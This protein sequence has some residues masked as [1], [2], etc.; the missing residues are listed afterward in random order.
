MVVGVLAAV[1]FTGVMATTIVR[2]TLPPSPQFSYRPHERPRVF[3]SHH[4][5]RAMPGRPLSIRVTPD[6]AAGYGEVTKAVAWLAGP[7]GQRDSRDCSEN[8]AVA[9]YVCQ[10]ELPQG[11]EIY[12][13]GGWIELN[14]SQRVTAQTSYRFQANLGLTQR[15]VLREP[16]APVAA[17]ADTYRLEVAWVRDPQNHS[18]ADF[19]DDLERI[20]YEG[21]LKDPVYR[22]RD[23]Q[24]TFSVTLNSGVT[25]SYYS[26]IDTR[27]G[28]N[29]WPREDQPF[30]TELNH[31]AVLAVVHRRTSTPDV[32]GGALARNFRDCA[33]TLVDNAAIRTFSVTGGITGTPIIAKHEFGHAAFGLGDEYTESDD[34]RRVPVPPTEVP[35]CCCAYDGDPPGFGTGPAMA[36]RR[37]PTPDAMRASWQFRPTICVSPGGEVERGLTQPGE[38]WPTCAATLP[39]E[40]GASRIDEPACP[41]LPGDCIVARMW[42][43]A[44]IPANVTPRPN[45][46]ISED[47][48]NAS[49]AAA[50]TH[51]GV[52]D[53]EQSLGTCEQICG[54]PGNPCPCGQAQGWIVDRDPAASSTRDS[55]ATSSARRHGGTCAWCVESSLC[56]RWQLALGDAPGQAWTRCSAPPE[57]AV[58]QERTWRSAFEALVNDLLRRLGIRT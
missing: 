30:P 38:A 18:E 13:Y 2:C 57:D 5:L 51:P 7:D 17:L 56:V 22:W 24:F 50:D 28:Q 33:G 55:M 54:Q 36:S 39:A 44:A 40:C 31:V 53:D 21:I 48:C 29:P 11:R 58:A 3:V 37:R 12:E 45:S 9:A 41:A 43:D 8:E 47:E 26:G 19:L 14:G 23:P 6:L 25:T 42:G 20:V 32:E 15:L 34:T 10:F 4:P 27:C 35:G 49:R 52:E 1:V 46:F 16:V